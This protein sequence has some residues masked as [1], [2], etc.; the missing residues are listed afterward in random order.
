MD[1]R[2]IYIALGRAD[3]WLKE[4]KLE[5]ARAPAEK[6]GDTWF[7][8]RTAKIAELAEILGV[9]EGAVS[10]APPPPVYQT[11]FINSGKPKETAQT[12]KPENPLKNLEFD[13]MQA[14]NESENRAAYLRGNKGAFATLYPNRDYTEFVELTTKWEE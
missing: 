1:N 4:R 7:I 2:A 5:L 6:R 3:Q 8:D 13:L 9:L 11:N 14:L 10:A 12:E